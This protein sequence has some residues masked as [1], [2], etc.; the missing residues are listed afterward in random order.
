MTISCDYEVISPEEARR[1]QARGWHSPRTIRR[2]EMAYLTLLADARSGN[3]RIDLRV[4]ADAV[5]SV[6][7]K[8]PS[9]LE[10]GCGSGYY[11]EIL[12]QLARSDV[13]YT[14]LDYSKAAIARARLRYPDVDFEVGDATALRFSDR[15]FD[16]VFN[17]VSLM[18]ILDYE[19]AI[20][21]AARVA[22]KAAIFHSVP[23]FET[24]PVAHLHKYAYGSPVVEVVFNRREL[25]S[26]F[27]RHGLRLV[28]SWPTIEYD[29]SAVVGA[30][31]H[32]ETFLCEKAS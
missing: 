14:G 3:P 9:L 5:D 10:I 25:I 27:E 21:E 28:K 11:S 8:A 29:V 6:G 4:A 20:A 18:H 12:A 1:R 31:S 7:L 16:I 30:S 19:K 24:A 22:A 23:V 15:S 32:A 2:Q 26:I 17:G 13:R